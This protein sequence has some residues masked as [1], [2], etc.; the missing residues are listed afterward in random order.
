M[1]L[2]LLLLSINQSIQTIPQRSA[3]PPPPPPHFLPTPHPNPD[4]LQDSNDNNDLTLLREF[5]DVHYWTREVSL[6]PAGTPIARVSPAP[7]LPG[8]PAPLPDIGQP[9]ADTS[10]PNAQV[11]SI[12]RKVCRRRSAHAWLTF[13]LLTLTSVLW[14]DCTLGGWG[15]FVLWRGWEL[16]K[17]EMEISRVL[18]LRFCCCCC[19][20]WWWWWWWCCCCLF[21]C[22]FVCSFVNPLFLNIGTS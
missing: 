5:N 20:W 4:V 10:Q 19:C 16:G 9:L 21:V 15:V 3:P 2:L 22:L 14:H 17:G 1:R 13:G 11:T 12:F 18:C 6:T 8:S 7:V